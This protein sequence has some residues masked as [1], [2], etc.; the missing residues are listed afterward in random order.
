MVSWTRKNDPTMGNGAGGY[1]RARLR[2]A[3]RIR[4]PS[5]P[6]I[7]RTVAGS[8]VGFPASAGT[9]KVTTAIPTCSNRTASFFIVILS[10]ITVTTVRLQGYVDYDITFDS[11]LEAK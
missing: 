4:A 7:S 11:E 10:V 6:P 5:P 2:R 1:F 9:T 8:G 3:I